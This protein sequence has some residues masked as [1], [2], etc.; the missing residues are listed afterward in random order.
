MALCRGHYVPTSLAQRYD[1]F[2][3]IDTTHALQPLYAPAAAGY[4]PQTWPEGE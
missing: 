1:A 3:F 2:V 4:V